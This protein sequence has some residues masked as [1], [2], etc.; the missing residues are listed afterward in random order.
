MLKPWIWRISVLTPASM[1]M[2]TL[3]LCSGPGRVAA[4]AV[5]AVAAAAV[6]V[7]GGPLRWL[8][9]VGCWARWWVACGI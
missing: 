1:Q 4:V 2:P 5:A 8:Q 7:V 6:A 3:F 9:V